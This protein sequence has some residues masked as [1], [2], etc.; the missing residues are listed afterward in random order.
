MMGVHQTI[1]AEQAEALA[2]VD[3]QRQP[4]DH[5]ALGLRGQRNEWVTKQ[6]IGDGI[7]DYWV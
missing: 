5:S 4:I 3:T 7:C 1:G 6:V 2:L